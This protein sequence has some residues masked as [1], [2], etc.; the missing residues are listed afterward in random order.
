MKSFK[1][2]IKEQKEL[3]DLE[4]QADVR[5]YKDAAAYCDKFPERMLSKNDFIKVLKKAMS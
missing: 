2:H 5:A 4:M 3:E 1:K